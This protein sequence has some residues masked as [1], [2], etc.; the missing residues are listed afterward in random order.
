MIYS[1]WCA[2]GR[3]SYWEVA[4]EGIAAGNDL[5]VPALPASTPLGV[6]SVEAGRGIPSGARFVGRGDVARGVIAPMQRDQLGMGDGGSWWSDGWTLFA[7]GV[8][9]GAGLLW[10]FSGKGR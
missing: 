1:E 7:G 5:P 9:V 4:S 2:D 8:A 6:P 3:Y 10:L